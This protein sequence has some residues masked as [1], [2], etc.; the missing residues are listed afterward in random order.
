LSSVIEYIQ[1]KYLEFPRWHV[2]DVAD[3]N[4]VVQRKGRAGGVQH[5]KDT[6]TYMTLRA[7]V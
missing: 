2:V 5:L 4:N 3:I 7:P 6:R 1:G